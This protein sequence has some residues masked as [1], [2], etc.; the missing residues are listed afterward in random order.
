MSKNNVSGIRY[1]ADGDRTA[2]PSGARRDSAV[3]KPR[4]SLLPLDLLR[5][6]SDWLALGAKLHGDNNWRK[7]QTQSRCFDSLMR[8]AEAF[9]SGDRVED[10]LSAIIFN[11]LSI[12]NVEEYYRDDPMLAD[13][14]AQFIDR[15]PT[16][17]PYYVPEQV[18]AVDTSEK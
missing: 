13:M 14:Y 8:H 3:G 1:N 15:K 4:M 11:A 9:Q 17:E 10:H 2:F 7:G 18:S 6:V 12:M 5:R 16:G